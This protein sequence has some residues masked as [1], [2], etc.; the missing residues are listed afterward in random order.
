MRVIAL[1]LFAAASPS[2]LAQ[3]SADAPATA[4]STPLQ[5]ITI[6]GTRTERRLQEV[7]ASISVIGS[8]QIER[9]QPQYVGD[10]LTLVP[11]LFLDRQEQ[12]SYNKVTIRGVPARHHNDTFLL[13][14]D[15]IP[16][17][18]KEEEIDLD[19]LPVDAIGRVEVVKGPMSALYGRGGV[20]G[21]LSYFT[22]DPF[23]ASSKVGVK[24]GSF[25]SVKPFATAAARL[26]DDA[27]VLVSASHEK[28]D[29]WADDTARRATS[30]FAKGSWLL[31][32]GS[33]FD[34]AAVH[35][36]NRQALGSYVPLDA[37]G[38]RV[39][40]ARGERAN[41][42][43]EDAHADRRTDSVYA[44][45]DQRLSA[46]WKAKLSASIARR[47]GTYQ[48][49]F[50][51]G[52]DA[53]AET[54]SWTGF[55]GTGSG[56]TGYFDAQFT[57]QLGAHR[58]VAGASAER[59]RSTSV[60]NWTGAPFTFYEQL[61]DARTGNV[62]DAAS[63]VT[64]RRLDARAS[65]RVLSAYV[66]D[67]IDL[68]PQWR[69]TLGLRHDRFKR[70]VD[71]AQ[72][73]ET[74]F[75]DPSG[76][77]PAEQAAAD[78]SRT[79][80]KLALTWNLAPET[81]LYASF[82]EGYSPALGP[83]WAFTGRPRELKPEIARGYE[84]GAK[85]S[86][87]AQSMSYAVALYVLD[88]KDL[89]EWVGSGGGAFSYLNVGKQRSQGVEVETTWRLDALARGLSAYANY[90]YTNASWRDK[91]IVDPFSGTPY[92]FTGKTVPGVPPHQLA[93]G[94]AWE[95]NA[96]WQ[97]FGG[98][99]AASRYYIDQP[100]SAKGEGY[101]VA[102]AGARWTPAQAPG[103]Q[104]Q[105]NVKNLFD[106]RYYSYFGGNDGPQYA[107]PAEPRNISITASYTFR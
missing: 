47:E 5:T 104:L 77:L 43:I 28:S 60:E 91:N 101:V 21:T 68:T 29:G 30:L 46:D 8:A 96:Q 90:A 85:G 37:Q 3:T 80:P 34:I 23:K 54:F 55:Q 33:S 56:T 81:T 95:A 105:L 62:L 40:L 22:V 39:P 18:T 76:T 1:L 50:Y 79:T 9:L 71:Y 31:G 32:G 52:Y 4:A 49:G 61:V 100:N 84:I 2:A 102:D 15:G 63:F 87:L 45:L 67:E 93:L 44:I 26:S 107:Q 94:A 65:A 6:T 19:F 66:Q 88:R 41:N 98:V 83:I 74:I 38:K 103:V 58:I 59:T 42:N 35:Y 92:D 14:V 25:A 72:G 16:R 10:E 73:Q 27:A 12:G 99:Q 89:A 78:G 48:G 86:A 75:G 13:L 82:G 69:L 70:N 57:G 97:L 24:A 64:D 7:P 11:G 51:N 36:R 106:K 17:V 53:V 20:A